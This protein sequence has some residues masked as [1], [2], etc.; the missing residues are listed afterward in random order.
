MTTSSPCV[1]NVRR[2]RDD[3]DMLYFWNRRRL[4]QIVAGGELLLRIGGVMDKIGGAALNNAGVIAFPAIYKGPTLGGIF[5]AGAENLRL[6]AGVGER[7]PS[8]PMILGFSERVAIHEAGAVSFGAYSG[9]GRGEYSRVDTADRAG[10]ARRD[11]G[12]GGAGAGRWPLWRVRTM[13]DRQSGRD[14][15]VHCR[16]RWRV[17][18]AGGVRGECRAVRPGR[19]D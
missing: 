12:T 1:A 14:G 9:E 3:L 8:G 16:P 15:R 10:A 13:A 17:R 4:R 6:L 5:V 7:A 2:G 19:D 18:A 11:R